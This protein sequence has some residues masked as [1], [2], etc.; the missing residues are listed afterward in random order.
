MAQALQIQHTNSTVQIANR[1]FRLPA[2]G[3][4]E[5]GRYQTVFRLAARR[6]R[7]SRCFFF[8]FVREQALRSGE[9]SL[10]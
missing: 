10:R 1:S 8:S 5:A 2:A 3:W 6:D 7:S 9:I 4:P